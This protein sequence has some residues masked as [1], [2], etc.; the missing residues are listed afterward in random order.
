MGYGIRV[1]LVMNRKGGS[2][3]STLCRALASAAAARGETVTIFD[4]D[5]SRSCLTW[6]QAGQEAGNWSPLVEVIH[7]L[8]AHRVV[9]AIDQIYE[10]HDQEH[11]IV[12]DTFGGG[13]EAQDVLAVAAHR[14]ICPMMLSRGDLSETRETAS[15]YLKLRG[16][17]EKPDAL[18]GFSVTLSRVPVRVSETERAVAE[19]LFQSLPAL[20]S[21]LANRSAYVRMDK[22]GLLGVIADK[23][24]NRAL[25]VH[26]QNAV[27]EAGELL[28][29]IDQLILAPAEVA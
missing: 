13:S 7:T 2:G 17:V 11:L 21:Y 28:D 23:T 10:Q 14:I 22:E 3:K 9:E 6:M 18:A 27:K 20:E 15:W 4:T 25:A 5:S 26:V 24:P 12:I 16:R 1:V 19:E 8:D 29:E